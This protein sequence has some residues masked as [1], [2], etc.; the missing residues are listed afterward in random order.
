[1]L[2]LI[3]QCKG[4]LLYAMIRNGSG[5]RYIV[6][7]PDLPSPYTAFYKICHRLGYRITRDLRLANGPVIAWEDTTVR[8]PDGGLTIY[9]SDHRVL[10]GA[11]RDISKKHGARVFAE[12]FGYTLTVDPETYVG[13]MVKKSNINAFHDGSIVTGPLHE[14]S[15][16]FVYQKLVDNV[17]DGRVRDLRIPVFGDIIPYC[18]DKRMPIEDRFTNETG[19]ATICELADILAPEEV[20]MILR[21]CRA[22]GLDY[23]E[24][25]VLRDNADGRLYIVDVNN[26]PYGPLD[27]HIE[28]SCYFD[29]TSWECLERMSRAFEKAFLRES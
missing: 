3:A 9:S 14:A 17:V 19:S 26:T 11:C 12:V 5:A 29:P 4:L 23:G 13:P 7:R 10:N 16:D 21:F 15:A 8:G 27:R 2:L 28:V 18:L 20:A 22:V 24:L 6:T 1:M 25:D